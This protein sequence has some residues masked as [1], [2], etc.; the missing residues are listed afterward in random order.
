MTGGTY[1]AIV[2]GTRL[3]RS[4]RRRT[5]F[6]HRSLIPGFLAPPRNEQRHRQ[7]KA[8]AEAE[9]GQDRTHRTTLNHL[10]EHSPFFSL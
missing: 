7:S 10:P 6:G 8:E 1:D 9:A 2:S 3:N 4:G 5:V